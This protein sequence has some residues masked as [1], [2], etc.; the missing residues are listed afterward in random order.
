[1]NKS[2]AISIIAVLAIAVIAVGYLYIQQ[3]NKLTEAESEIVALQ[4]NVSTLEEN[5]ANSETEASNLKAELAD[6]E[7]KMSV[8]ESDLQT[9]QTELETAN[10]EVE[11]LRAD[12]AA[13]QKINSSLTDEVKNITH[14]RHFESLTELTD[15]LRQ[16]D[17]DIEYA[18]ED[19]VSMSYILQVKALRDGYLLPVNIDDEPDGLFYSNAAMIED[20]LHWVWADNDYTEFVAYVQPL[21]SRPIALD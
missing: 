11:K 7:A 16:D 10:N 20:E 13:Q 5:L 17:T 14:P 12:V 15:W 21:P 4:S 8:L 2:I 1:M 6:T 3:T 18:G 9:A 19:F